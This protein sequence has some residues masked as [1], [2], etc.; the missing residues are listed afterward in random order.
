MN[1]SPRNSS[2]RLIL[3]LTILG[4][5]G[6]VE[7]A[8]KTGAGADALASDKAACEQAGGD[9]PKC[10]HDKGWTIANLSGDDP[11]TAPAAGTAT[12]MAPPPAPGMAAAPP[13]AAPGSAGTAPAPASPPPADPMAPVKMTAWVKF[14]GGGPQDDIAACVATLGPTSAPDTINHTVTRALLSCMRA[15]G[16][17]GL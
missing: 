2:H 14:G 4:L 9:Y 5:S 7:F 16:W 11:I 1:S 15:K 6:C 12:A 8:Y 3:S 13:A 17:R 10:M